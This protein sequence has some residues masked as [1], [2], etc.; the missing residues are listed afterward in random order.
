MIRHSIVASAALLCAVSGA[1]A[2]VTETFVASDITPDIFQDFTGVADVQLGTALNAGPVDLNPTLPATATSTV[3]TA[4]NTDF[5]ILGETLEVFIDPGFLDDV[6]FTFDVPILAFGA[7]NDAVNVAPSVLVEIDGQTFD[8]VNGFQGFISD[9]PFTQVT[10][11]AAVPGT[12]DF[13]TVDDIRVQLVPEPTSL[14]L[15]G[16]G[17]LVA[18]RRRR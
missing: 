14:A 11:R 2:V 7:V 15:A 5:Q 17:G 10:Y 12:I 1:S 3:S 9:T 13:Y 4:F 16:L 18:L 8:L 6:T